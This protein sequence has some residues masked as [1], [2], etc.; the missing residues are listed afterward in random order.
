ME[1]I[2]GRFC[3][4]FLGEISERTCR[5]S[6]EIQRKFTEY[7]DNFLNV[8]LKENFGGIYIS[9]RP[10]SLKEFL[11]ESLEDFF[12]RITEEISINLSPEVPLEGFLEQIINKLGVAEVIY[13]MFSSKLL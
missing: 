3:K 13:L 6:L 8:F 12:T 7:L 10:E 11:Q 1:A 5:G 2:H 4:E 9:K